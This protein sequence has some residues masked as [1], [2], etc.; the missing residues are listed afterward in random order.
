MPCF[1]SFLQCSKLECQLAAY[2]TVT[3][4]CHFLN[5]HVK[6]FWELSWKANFRL[7]VPEVVCWNRA[8]PGYDKVS[9]SRN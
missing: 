7:R 5:L 4:Q 1:S 9:G 8:N 2:A 3:E 6:A